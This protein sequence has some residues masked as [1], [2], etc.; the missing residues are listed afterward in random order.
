MCVHC[1]GAVAVTRRLHA[2]PPHRHPRTT[3]T[4]V[5]TATIHQTRMR[6]ATAQTPAAKLDQ[7]MPGQPYALNP[8]HSVPPATVQPSAHPPTPT[9]P[10]SQLAPRGAGLLQTAVR[11]WVALLRP[12]L[13]W[14]RL[15]TARHLACLD[16]NVGAPAKDPP[17][18]GR[19]R[20]A[21]LVAGSYR[22]P[23]VVSCQLVGNDTPYCISGLDTAH[24]RS[25]R[26]PS[27]MCINL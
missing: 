8:P 6:P 9:P 19:W 13:S 2:T 14:L 17:W 5:T 24:A 22:G 18:E 7:C 12:P 10:H 27:Y 23:C 1:S 16:R 15:Q 4:C 11:L 3:G 25:A 26:Q 21:R 20:P